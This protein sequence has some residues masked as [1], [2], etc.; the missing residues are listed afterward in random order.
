[1]ASNA[2]MTS[3]SASLYLIPSSPWKREISGEKVA[4]GDGGGEAWGMRVEFGEAAAAAAAATAA[5]AT[6]WHKGQQW[7]LSED[8]LVG[9]SSDSRSAGTMRSWREEW[10]KKQTLRLQFLPSLQASVRVEPALEDAVGELAGVGAWAGALAEVGADG[11]G[12][13]EAAGVAAAG[14]LAGVGEGAVGPVVAAAAAALADLEL[15][16]TEV[17]RRVGVIV[18]VVGVGAGAGGGEEL[19][20]GGG[21]GGGAVGVVVVVVAELAGRDVEVAEGRGLFGEVV[22]VVV[23]LVQLLLLIGANAT[24]HFLFLFFGSIYWCEEKEEDGV[25]VL[26]TFGANQFVRMALKCYD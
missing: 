16:H 2:A 7:L 15:E 4:G 3:A 13:A 22:V 11:A 18:R 12:V 14:L 17:V 5:A 19:G 25:R 23:E 1:M 9:E 8:V 10:A 26:V 21:G 20:E 24:H 6:E